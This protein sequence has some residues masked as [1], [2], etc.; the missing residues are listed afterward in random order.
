MTLPLNKVQTAFKERIL[1]E[2]GALLFDTTFNQELDSADIPLDI[3]LNVY[4]NN[5]LSG[6]SNVLALNFPTIKTLVGEEFF[7]AVAKLYIRQN[8]PQQGCANLY[9]E[10]FAEFLHSLEQT[11][12]L[13][14]LYDVAQYDWA[15]N[16]G[17]HAADDMGLRQEDLQ[18]ISPEQYADLVL[19]PRASLSLIHSSYPL[20]SIRE[21]CGKEDEDDETLDLD[22]GG[23]YL[24]VYRPELRIVVVE[25][26]DDEFAMLTGIQQGKNLGEAF[27]TVLAVYPNFDFQNFL[28]KH[29]HLETFCTLSTN[30]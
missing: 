8:P 10:S 19:N 21:F 22:A 6:L 11:Q 20:I 7:D 26:E 1:D 3:R 12:E 9:G 4:R 30:D 29:M 2:A 13:P 5:V 27:E 23:V 16:F 14:Y 28:Q 24:M 15:F 18:G 25:L 17:Y